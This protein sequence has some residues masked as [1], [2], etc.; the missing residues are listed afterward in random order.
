MNLKIIIF[1]IIICYVSTLEDVKSNRA[2]ILFVY[3]ADEADCNYQ[4]INKRISLSLRQAI[5][6]QQGNRI[7][8]AANFGDCGKILSYDFKTS[9]AWLQEQYPDVEFIDTTKIGSH[10]YSYYYYNYYYDNY[11]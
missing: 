4:S 7:I 11:L 6:T 2:N 9:L 5:F 10:Y 3:D 8:F 1:F